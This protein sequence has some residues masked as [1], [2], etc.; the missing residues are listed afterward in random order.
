MREM[1]ERFLARGYTFSNME[2]PADNTVS[3]TFDDGYA[4]NLLFS[5]L[6][7]QYDIPFVV[8]VSAYYNQSGEGFPWLKADGQS[9]VQMHRFDYYAFHE[10]RGENRSPTLDA[11][12][13]RPMTFD[14]LSTLAGKGLA[15]IGCHGFY[16]QPLSKEFEK[17]APQEQSLAMSMLDERLGEKPRYYALANG[18]YTGR[19]VRQLLKTFTK[20]FTID[21]MAYRRNDKVIHRLSL[22]NPNISGP[23]Y[24]QIARSMYF[25]RQIKRAIRVK[26]RLFV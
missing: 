13:E 7:Q 12:P 1:I 24:D 14:E 22:T 18:M 4:N 2:D 16:H 3:I 8:F 20:V 6:A 21:G 10:E 5:D 17:Y 11:S 19:V 15:E 23:L 25:P 26:S 9:Y